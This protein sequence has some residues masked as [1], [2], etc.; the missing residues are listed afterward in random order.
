ME[1]DTWIWLKQEA[2]KKL[3]EWMAGKCDPNPA[4][5]NHWLRIVSG[6][7][8]YGYMLEKDYEKLPHAIS[9]RTQADVLKAYKNGL[10]VY[11]RS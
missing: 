9:L 6:E 4:V 10:L 5:T 2:R 8:P 11:R 7:M 3:E 1:E